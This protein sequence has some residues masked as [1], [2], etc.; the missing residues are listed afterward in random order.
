MFDGPR[1]V[2]IGSFAAFDYFG[3][4]SFYL[5]DSPGHAVGHLCGL[6]RTTSDTFVLMGGDVAHY[7]GIIRPSKHLQLP[8][9]ISPHPCHPESTVPMCPGHAFEDLQKSR[10]RKVTDTLYDLTYGGDIPLA[11]ETVGRLQELDCNDNIMVVIAHDGSARDYL[12]HFP[13]DLN[14]WKEQ[15][16]GKKLRW[17]FLRDLKSYWVSKGIA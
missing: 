1:V 11:K 9:S 5:L 12:P 2:S 4:G 16:L 7:S 6:A 17:S 13:Q 8:E 3:D 15:G 10:G 14:S